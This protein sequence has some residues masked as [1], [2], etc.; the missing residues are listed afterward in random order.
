MNEA[1][2]RITDS[3]FLVPT[4]GIEIG[5]VLPTSST[6]T[7]SGRLDYSHPVM[8]EAVQLFCVDQKLGMYYKK[9]GNHVFYLGTYKNKNNGIFRLFSFPVR[10]SANDDLDLTT[11]VHSCEDLITQADKFRL[12]CIL[13]PAFHCAGQLDS[14]NNCYRDTLGLVLDDRFILVHRY[15]DS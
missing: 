4:S 7:K 2:L 3:I 12:S 9:Y 14:F 5:V 15:N 13:L 8:Q 6:A 1:K 10:A 11:I